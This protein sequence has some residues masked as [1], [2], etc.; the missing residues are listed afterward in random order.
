MLWEELGTKRI[1]FEAQGATC[2]LVQDY[3]IFFGGDNPQSNALNVF[4]LKAYKWVENLD[5]KG[6]R[7]ISRIKHTAC[8]MND[9]RIIF[10]GG[11][12]PSDDEFCTDIL[13]LH[14]TI[15]KS[16]FLLNKINLS[17]G[18]SLTW[19]QDEKYSNSRCPQR[20]FHTSNIYKD[21]MYVFAGYNNT[22]TSENPILILNLS[23]FMFFK[24]PQLR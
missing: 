14:V 4:D 19:E 12:I 24:I 1:S 20:F 23:K 22:K 9:N 8:L 2:T 7:P 5:I 16:K 6:P 11:R 13:I 21:K 15:N 3:L 17:S 10:Y 18:I